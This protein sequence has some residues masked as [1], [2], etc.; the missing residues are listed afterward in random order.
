MNK[1]PFIIHLMIQCRRCLAG[2]LVWPPRPKVASTRTGEAALSCKASTEAE[3]ERWKMLE[4]SFTASHRIHPGTCAEDWKIATDWHFCK[5]C[6]SFSGEFS[7]AASVSPHL[8]HLI[9]QDWPMTIHPASCASSL[10]Q[11]VRAPLNLV[12]LNDTKA[13]AKL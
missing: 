4:G 9:T 6:I 8:N 1:V 2:R 5:L 7:L 13:S 11:E 10:Y 3:A 12:V